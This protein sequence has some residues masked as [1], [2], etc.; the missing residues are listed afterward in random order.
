MAPKLRVGDEANEQRAIVD[1]IGRRGAEL[2]APQA[3]RPPRAQ[4]VRCEADDV[5]A[6][7]GLRD[8]LEVDEHHLFERKV[9]RGHEPPIS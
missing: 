1:A 7:S 5:R 2:V 6:L 9:S 3:E 4:F 8:E